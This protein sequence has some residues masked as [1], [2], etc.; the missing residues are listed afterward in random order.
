MPSSWARAMTCPATASEC[1]GEGELVGQVRWVVQ[2]EELEDVGVWS[3]RARGLRPG[4]ATVAEGAFAVFE[5]AD[6]AGVG[7]AVLGNAA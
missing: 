2:G 5:P 6:R 4:P 3:V 7:E 1:I